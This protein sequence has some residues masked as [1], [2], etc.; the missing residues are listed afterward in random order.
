MQSD[1]LA[2]PRPGDH[3]LRLY[4]EDAELVE[5]LLPF[6]THGIGRGEAVVLLITRQHRLQLEHRLAQNDFP[7]ALL[8]SLGRVIFADAAY[9]LQRLIRHGKPDLQLFRSALEGLLTQAE[10]GVAGR[11]VRIFGELVDLLWRG[12]NIAAATELEGF[13]NE[14]LAERRFALFCAYSLEDGAS[15]GSFSPEICAAHTHVFDP[16]ERRAGGLS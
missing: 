8:H 7:I 5:A 10:A 12:G 4:T 14:A 16:E 6:V 9:M 11:R 15:A 1:L 2:E 3:F 13:W